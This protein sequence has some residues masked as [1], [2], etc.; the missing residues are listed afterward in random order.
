MSMS[1]TDGRPTAGERGPRRRRLRWQQHPRLPRRR[2]LL[3]R[4]LTQTR[5]RTRTR[6]LTLTDVTATVTVP[7]P[8]PVTLTVTGTVTVAVAVTVT[9]TVTVTRRQWVGSAAFGRSDNNEVFLRLHAQLVESCA[10]EAPTPQVATSEGCYLA[11]TH[12]ALRMK[13]HRRVRARGA[14]Q[15]MLRR[16]LTQLPRAPPEGCKSADAPPRPAA[17]APRSARGV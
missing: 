13:A 16:G 7:V 1:V 11:D 3:D 5:T 2:R 10:P 15:R 12:G 6:N 17:A 9:V 14:S 8:V 4:V